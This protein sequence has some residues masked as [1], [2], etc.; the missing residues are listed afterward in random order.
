MG[1]HDA[2][3]SHSFV[4]RIWREGHSTWDWRGWIQHA[5]TGEETYVRD[6]NELLAFIERRAGRLA[7]SSSDP[8]VPGAGLK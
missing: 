1:E 6:L 5:G 2:T 3:R 8:N 4:I 7:G